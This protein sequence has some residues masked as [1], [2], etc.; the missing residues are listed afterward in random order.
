MAAAIEIHRAADDCAA[1]AKALADRA[2]RIRADAGRHADEIRAAQ[3]E[4]TR[5]AMAHHARAIS[6]ALR[7]GEP[8][9][10][11]PTLPPVNSAALV[12]AVSQHDALEVSAVELALEAQDAAAVAAVA[13]NDVMAI[14]NS[15]LDAEAAEITKE[16]IAVHELAWRLENRLSGIFRLDARRSG[17]R[18]RDLEE[19]LKQKIDIRKREEARDPELNERWKWREHFEGIAARSDGDWTAYAR[20][21]ASDPAATFEGCEESTQ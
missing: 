11:I 18:L 5:E 16:L 14:I 15:I 19:D 8:V 12:A 9:P 6:E 10:G 7:A 20:R 21:L 17:P 13:A 1:A 3:G 2:E 4:R